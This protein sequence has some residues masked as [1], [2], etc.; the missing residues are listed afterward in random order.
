MC[1]FKYDFAEYRKP[2][3]AEPLTMTN[4]I[5]GR[6]EEQALLKKI[7]SRDPAD[8][9]AVYGRRRVG[10]TYL[11]RHYFQEVECVYFEVTGLKDGALHDQLKLFTEKLSAAFYQGLPLQPPQNWLDAFKLLSKAFETIPQNTKIIFFIDEIPWFASQKSGFVQAL[12]YYWNTRW[13]SRPGLKVIVCGSAASWM[14][15][16]LVHAKGGLHNRLTEIMPLMPFS[17]RET[18][19]CLVH[20]GIKFN[21]RQI[22]ELYMAIG[23]IP[24]YLNGIQPG[25]SVAQNLNRLCFQKDGF[26]FSEF[27]NLF[28]SLFDA[29]EAHNEIIRLIAKARHGVS[30]EEILE[31]SKYSSSGG[32]FKMRLSELEEAGFIASFTPHG[33]RNK[34]T[35]FRIIDEYVMFYLKWIEPAAQRLKPSLKNT[36]YWESRMQS[37]GWKS[38][39]GYA[40]EST[41]LKH[42]E[43]IKYAL[44]LHAISTE[45]GSWRYISGKKGRSMEDGAG[46]QIDL[47]IDRADGIINLCEIKFHQGKFVISKSYA[48]NL[49]Q[50][51]SVYQTHHKTNKPIYVTMITAE[52]I[53][54]NENSINLGVTEVTLND[55]FAL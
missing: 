31:K 54:P 29:S 28:A 1:I 52:G 9:L 47:L 26:L 35:F 17:L 49:S 40:F 34:G 46:C 4:N 38:W 30:R 20:K 3:R 18:E 23:G 14:L 22:V 42:I 50:K 55:L 33:N 24:H 25:L 10:K 19:E 48:D 8:L 11:I 45:V 2:Y 39:A 43:Q 6:R 41:C 5:T 12:D 37:Q 15:S 36:S 32:M 21:R 44:G 27:S 16:N 53:H 51:I 13:S 7:Y